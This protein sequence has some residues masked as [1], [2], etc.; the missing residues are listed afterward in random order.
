MNSMRK[1]T[2]KPC[3][4]NFS[5][6]CL[7]LAISQAIAPTVLAAN[8]VVDTSG[9]IS[10]NDSICTLREAIESANSNPGN[11]ENGCVS[12]DSE[13]VDSI[14][15]DLSVFPIT[16][17]NNSIALNSSLPTVSESATITGQG[18][19]GLTIDAQSS[20]SVILV[21]NATVS[22]N[23]LNITGGNANSGGGILVS[24]GS[25]TLSN[26]SVSG[27]SAS[28][29]GGGIRVVSGH[30]NLN[31][32]TVSGNHA[33]SG[34][35]GLMSSG[36][37]SF[38]LSNSTVTGNS[39]SHSGGGIYAHSINVF[40]SL[41]NSTVS[42]NSAANRSGGIHVFAGASVNLSNST[43][44]NNSA[45]SLGGGVFSNSSSITLINSTVTGNSAATGGGISSFTSDVSMTNNI[46]A[47]NFAEVGAE[48]NDYDG[49]TAF[50][51][52]NNLFG[53][54]NHTNAAAFAN[55]TPN[56]TA[57]TGTSNGTHRR[58]I[59]ATLSPLAD[60]GGATLTHAL[61]DDSLAIDAGDT[62]ICES[63]PISSLDQRGEIRP[64]GE[65]C[66]IGSYEGGQKTEPFFTVPLSDG[67]AVIFSL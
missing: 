63:E 8:I 38:A 67:K 33:S 10:T 14:G 19:G 54:S 41:S 42:G 48:I 24:S 3:H 45:G 43:V 31:N 65:A 34:G 39:S 7:V 15:F 1:I 21:S 44:S 32:S 18:I 59:S 4:M 22:L 50:T 29:F 9:D 11:S 20:G 17:P 62:A 40:F 56:T 47:G 51:Q 36:S 46:I 6:S 60:N 49:T 23:S 57:I 35:G 12:G 26:S 66:D 61:P 5:K 58:N 37:G 52:H 30:V 16:S 25:V 28:N 53:S 27:N 64:A 2:R 55:F 13:L